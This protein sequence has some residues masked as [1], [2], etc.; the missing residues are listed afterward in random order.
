MY[1]YKSFRIYTLDLTCTL[2]QKCM[3]QYNV[4]YSVQVKSGVNMRKNLYGYLIYKGY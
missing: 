2:Y 1:S 4:Q 3:F